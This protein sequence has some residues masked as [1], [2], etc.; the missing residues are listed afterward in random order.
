MKKTILK[1]VLTVLVALVSLNAHAVEI[2]GISYYLNDEKLTATVVSSQSEKYSGTIDIPASVE[3]GG[4]VYAVTSI[5]EE[6]FYNCSGLT[7]LTIPEGITSIGYGAFEGCSGLT[8]LTIPEGVTS[9]GSW[10]FYGCSV[11]SS[12]YIPSSVTSIGGSAFFGCESLASVVVDPNNTVYNSQGD[13]NAIIETATNTLVTGCSKTIIPNNITSIGSGAFGFCRSLTNLIIP[14]SVISIGYEAFFGCDRL[15]SLTIPKSVTSIEERAF[16]GCSNLTSI[17]VDKNNPIYDSR[18]N[19]NALIETATNTLVTGCSNTVIPNEITSIGNSAFSGC[20]GLTNVVL[21]E[22]V[23]EISRDAF[24]NCNG[25]TSVTIPNSITSIGVYAFGSCTNLTSLIIPNSVT[26]I[27]QLAFINCENLASIEF[28]SSELIIDYRAFDNTAWY[29]NQE[30]GLVYAGNVAYKYKGEMPENT[31]ITIKDGTVSIA[32]GA[33]MNCKGLTTVTIPSSV[34]S[35]FGNAFN[36]CN[37]LTDVYCYA[38]SVPKVL[39]DPNGTFRGI[40]NANL[41]VPNSSIAD[42]RSAKG[43]A[44][45]SIIGG[46][47]Y[48]WVDLIENGD[49]EKESQFQYFYS[50]EMSLDDGALLKSRVVDGEGKD[51]TKGIVVHT[52]DRVLSDWD[53]QFYICLPFAIPSWTPILVEF[54]YK[55]NNSGTVNTSG[56]VVMG[57][58]ANMGIGRVNMNTE[59]SHFK[60]LS[61]VSNIYDANANGIK[62]VAFDLNGIWQATDFYFDNISFN[63][64]KEDWEALSN[65]GA[66]IAPMENETVIAFEKSITDETDLTN[67]VIENVYVTLDTKADDGYDKEDKC[68]VLTSTMT[69]EQ[70]EGISS[71][72]VGEAIVKDNFNGLILEVPAG[73][74]TISIDALTKGSRSLNVKIGDAETQ[75]FVQPERGEVEIPYNVTEATYVYIY[76]ADTVN[77]VKHRVSGSQTENGVLIYG[78]KWEGVSTGINVV[79]A[80]H[81]GTNRIFTIDG[82]SSNSLQKGVNIIRTQDGKTRKVLMK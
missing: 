82:S 81:D 11:L 25:L 66:E 22:G 5:G 19:C 1:S 27:D 6:A 52:S 3:Y 58:G 68:I 26:T 30:D 59:W 79:A 45:F 32:W 21:P 55:A 28:P 39:D 51:G 34:T 49:L 24:S 65:T 61:Y 72:D 9:I 37:G 50:K 18:E 36:Y 77:G 20:S 56:H 78:V 67:A 4:N 64:L 15:T 47:V 74:G 53:N 62:Y 43:W 2:D 54:D 17:V 40:S 14:E 8:S 46:I 44:S 57:V 69:E 31:S 33:F 63:L 42:Y 71:K 35:I 60:Y 29:N 23:T 48:E 73:T 75:M 10:A 7:S 41:H 16:S 13:V 38:E 70:V 12:I 80:A 76:G